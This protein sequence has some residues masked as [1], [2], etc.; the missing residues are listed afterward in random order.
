MN[1]RSLSTVLLLCYC[2]YAAHVS[3]AQVSVV[4]MEG[5]AFIEEIK[6][7]KPTYKK[8]VY[9]PLPTAETIVLKESS[10]LRLLDE[11]NRICTLSEPGTYTVSKLRF[12]KSERNS[13]FDRFCDYF[14]SFFINH[15]TSESKS[16]YKNSIHAISR[17]ILSAPALDFPLEGEL[18]SDA[19][20]LPFVWS[21]ACDT[22]QYVLSINNLKTK[23]NVYAHT[24][25]E[26]T[27]TLEE[28]SRFLTPGEQYYWS[29]NVSGVEVTSENGIFS[30]AATGAYGQ[31]V[32]QS[33][34]VVQSLSFESPEATTV[35]VMSDMAASDDINFGLLYGFDMQIEHP[36]NAQIA[37]LVQRMWYD[38]LS[39]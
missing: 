11:E 9:G 15:S 17:G 35:F 31:K 19:G 36:D 24:G 28:P 4:Y 20:P 25:S 26:K 23:A 10:S 33:E 29:V 39:E 13:M 7:E 14:H 6:Q 27:V 38:M 8:I 37:D 18:P 21:H 30:V 1:T 12:E 32:K 2:L 3:T 16:N 22:C 34:A 5:D